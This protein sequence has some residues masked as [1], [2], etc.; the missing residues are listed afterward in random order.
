MQSMWYSY[1]YCKTYI[2]QASNFR[3]LSKIAK[4]NT[5][6][7]LELIDGVRLNVPP[8]TL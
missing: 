3:D 8:N 2:S 5:R 4:L 6:E 7:F 1:I